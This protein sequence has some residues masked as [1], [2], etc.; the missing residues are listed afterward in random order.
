MPVTL[1]PACHSRTPFPFPPPWCSATSSN[2]GAL[3]SLADVDPAAS[4]S[5]SLVDTEA[6]QLT[7][8][9]RIDGS[10]AFASVLLLLLLLALSSNRILG[11]ERFF[12]QWVREMGMQKRYRER[13]Q[14]ISTRE[15]LER[16]FSTEGGEGGSSSGSGSN[17]SD[18]P[19]RSGS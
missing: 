17:G 1:Y 4:Q 10:A 3:Q 16:Q 5:F 15:Q 8:G 19:Q 7:M 14:L 13:N 12:V 18:G 2:L 6:L 11:L 9:P